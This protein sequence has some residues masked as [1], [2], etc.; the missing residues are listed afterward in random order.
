VKLTECLPDAHS[1]KL[2]SGPRPTLRVAE[3][4]LRCCRQISLVAVLMLL[5]VL[6]LCS[7]A[8]AA[9]ISVNTTQQGV[10]AGQ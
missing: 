7:R 9:T 8:Q 1:E 4:R 10:T 2:S 3:G 6:T 5:V